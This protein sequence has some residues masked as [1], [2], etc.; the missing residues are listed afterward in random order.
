[1]AALPILRRGGDEWLNSADALD[2]A[3][4]H[5]EVVTVS[6]SDLGYDEDSDAMHPKEYHNS[7]KLRDDVFV[8]PHHD[9]AVLS[10]GNQTWPRC[11]VGKTGELNSNLENEV[12]RILRETWPNGITEEMDHREIG[13]AGGHEIT[14]RVDVLTPSTPSE[15][16][17]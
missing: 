10:V 13:S 6:E 16:D 1:M 14:R 2:L 3:K 5:S 17:E 4:V 8:V 9:G 12:R 15:E 7:F 11:V